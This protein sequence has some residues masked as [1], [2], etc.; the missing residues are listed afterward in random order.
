MPVVHVEAGL[1]SNDRRMPEEINRVLTDQISD[2]ALH[3]RAQRPRQPAREGIARR[4]RVCFV[5]NVMI[6]SLRASRPRPCRRPRRCSAWPDASCIAGGLR[7]G[8]AAPPVQRRRC[9]HPAAR[10]STPCAR[11]RSACR[12]SS[13]CIR[14]RATTSSASACSGLDRHAAH[15]AAAAGLPGDAR[16][17][18]RRTLVLTDSGGLQEETTALGVPCLTMRENTERPI[19][20]EQGTNTMV[21]RDRGHPVGRPT[22]SCRPAASAAA[23]PNSGTAARRAHRRRPAPTGCWRARWPPAEAHE[24]RPQHPIT[25][26]LTIDV[27]DYFQVSALAPHIRAAS[28]TAVSAASS[29]TSTAS[30]RCST[31]RHARH[32]LHP[33]LDRR[34]LPAAGAAHRRRRPRTGQP[35]LRPRARQ[36]PR[37]RS[38]HA[39]IRAPRPARRHR[40]RGGQ[41]LPRAQLLDR[42]RQPVGARLPAAE[43]GYRYSSSIYPIRTTTTACPT[44]R[45]LP[46]RSSQRPARSAGDHAALFGRNWPASGGGYFRLLPYACRAG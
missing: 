4:A 10:C 33:G 39:D 40:R 20:V 30:S 45:A 14:A 12:W 27:E 2:R 24:Q 35:R 7:R 8:H 28:G 42:H 17:D 29:A 19:T 46:P 41:G 1:R 32:L 36:R 21:G 18:G 34:A 26:A 13:R 15:P 37:P 5:G 38:L 31:A 43:T 9:R 44:R 6:D 23:C 3:H 16:P 22:T 11:S 25:N